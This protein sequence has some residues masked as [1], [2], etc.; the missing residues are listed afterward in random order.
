MTVIQMSNQIE[1]V[2]D[3]NK[4]Q[5]IDYVEILQ[6]PNLLKLIID[7]VHK[8]FYGEDDTIMALITSI[9]TRLVVNCKPESK[10]I[11]VSELSGAG[12]DRLVK[13][14]CNVLLKDEETYLHRAKLTPEVFTYW[15][16]NDEDWSWDGKVI[17]LEDPTTELMNCQSI[18]TMASG[19]KKATVVDKQKARDL[20]TKGKP[21]LIITT[22]TGCADVEG[23]RRYPFIHMDTSQELTKEVIRN[24]LE[25]AAGVNTP[26]PDMK[27]ISALQK[28]EAQKVKI[29][30]AN[31]LFSHIPAN[32]VMRTY[33]FRLLDYIKASAILHQYQREFNNDNEL[34]AMPQD[35]DLGRIAFLKTITNPAMLPLSRDQET[36]L[37]V[38]SSST[39]PLFVAD[40]HKRISRNRDWI[41]RNCE[42]LKRY[43]LIYQTTRRKDDANKDV[44]AFGCMGLSDGHRI[45]P[46]DRLSGFR[47]CRRNKT[48]ASSV[49]E[50]IDIERAKH[51][52]KP[53]YECYISSTTTT[54]IQPSEKPNL[55][56]TLQPSDN[57][58]DLKKILKKYKAKLV[59]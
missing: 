49:L 5:E 10:N 57:Q 28:L 37:D 43:D 35:Y 25:Q 9:C 50:S 45:P 11:V 39:E 44:T 56:T 38:I 14:V 16:T 15:H 22:F 6:N 7:E 30:F 20:D 33:I 8:N 29:P 32:L 12:K 4:E 55:T 2:E 26:I 27:L 59:R 23:V 42:I 24:A 3:F 17:H 31:L 54:T 47:G 21:N 1:P 46:T 41:Y 40:I 53:L 58:P 34:I 13:S 36:L 51:K 52:K 48:F 18:K 19:E